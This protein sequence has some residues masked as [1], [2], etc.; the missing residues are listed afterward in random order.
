[1][2]DPNLGNPQAPARRPLVERSDR[3]YETIL[4]VNAGTTLGVALGTLNPDGECQYVS[5]RAVWK[6]LEPHLKKVDLFV[7]CYWNATEEAIA[8]DLALQAR[9]A[10]CETLVTHATYNEGYQVRLPNRYERASRTLERLVRPRGY[11]P[12]RMGWFSP[13]YFMKMAPRKGEK[14]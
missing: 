4:V 7:G 11:V 5:G 14:L 6:A 13:T 2:H 10:G 12:R 9:E 3:R 8:H 1:M